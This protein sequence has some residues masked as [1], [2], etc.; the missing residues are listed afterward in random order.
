LRIICKI[1]AHNSTIPSGKHRSAIR[2]SV[3]PVG[4]VIKATQSLLNSRESAPPNGILIGSS[5][6]AQLI[7]VP[8]HTAPRYLR[9]VGKGRIYVVSLKQDTQPT[10]GY[11]CGKY[12]PIFKTLLLADSQC[13]NNSPES[14]TDAASVRLGL[15]VWWT[16]H[17]CQHV[18]T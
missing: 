7:R 5:V 10:F 16:I 9:R 15:A 8:G 18:N 12:E 14:I 3:C 11:N 6:S 1:Y 13:T 17:F 2:P 4:R